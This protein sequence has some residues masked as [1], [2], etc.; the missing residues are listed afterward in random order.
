M[1]VVHQKLLESATEGSWDF[2]TESVTSSSID[3]VQIQFSSVET[4]NG[5]GH[6][7]G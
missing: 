5:R 6:R 4:L 7:I 3:L 2:N 1:L